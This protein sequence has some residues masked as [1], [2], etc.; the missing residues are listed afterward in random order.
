[1]LLSHYSDSC[2]RQTERFR[3][4]HEIFPSFWYVSVLVADNCHC[5]SSRIWL[6]IVGT[7]G[8]L[9]GV[10]C[11]CEKS[12]YCTSVTGFMVQIFMKCSLCVLYQFACVQ[13]DFADTV[14]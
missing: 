3:D 6:I 13:A 8:M 12:H 1:M 7:N 4:R 10:W 9:L 2:Y 11:P 5:K 14:N